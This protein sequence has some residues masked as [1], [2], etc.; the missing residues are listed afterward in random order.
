MRVKDL[1]H[2]VEIWRLVE[3]DPGT[4]S[5]YLD[6]AGA[7]LVGMHVGASRRAMLPLDEGLSVDGAMLSGSLDLLPPDA[8]VNLKQTEASLILTAEGRR[9]VLRVHRGTQPGERLDFKAMPFDATWLREALPFLKACTSGGVVTPVLTG[10]HF[11]S[12]ERTTL[13]AT[14]AASRTGRLSLTMPC[15]VS[16]QVVPAADFE[17]AL[18]LLG[19]KIALKFSKGHLRLRDKTTT[20]KVSLLQGAYPDL[21]KLPQLRDYKHQIKVQKSQLDT[22]IRAGK[23]LDSDR[24]VT[25]TVKDKQAALLVRGQETGGFRQPISPCDLDDIEIMF[26][27]HWLDAAQY[28]GSST[29]LR[30]N[31]ERSPVLFSG[32]KR[33]LWMSP[34]VR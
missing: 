19:K 31:N 5:L 13:E 23:L 20:I 18:S 29:R 3:K 25:F 21:S 6:K 14:D 27:A 33:L 10:I 32:N 34:V 24:L 4:K 2:L 7:R 1:S 17:T 12:G 26:D 28:V 11:V 9:A 22:A 8:T 16:G 15:D 30:Y